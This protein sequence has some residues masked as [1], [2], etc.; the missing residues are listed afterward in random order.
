MVQR[1]GHGCWGEEEDGNATE[2]LAATISAGYVE[3]LFGCSQS[4]TRAGTV[5]TNHG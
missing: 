3:N 5:S 4:P 1:L 2:P